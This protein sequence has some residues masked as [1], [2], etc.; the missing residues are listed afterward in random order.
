MAGLAR[1]VRAVLLDVTG[2]LYESGPD[3]GKAI[4]GSP[5]AVQRQMTSVNLSGNLK[6]FFYRLRQ[7]GFNLR[8]CTNETNITRRALVEKLKRHG[9]SLTEDE[10]HSPA[11]AC[12]RYLSENNLRPYLIGM[13]ITIHK[14]LVYPGIWRG[15]QIILGLSVRNARE[16]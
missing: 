3:G 5:E 12:C 9:F 10:V 7:S 6:D 15:H 16:M 8:F 11:P 4:T 14:F 13:R 2:V 1:K